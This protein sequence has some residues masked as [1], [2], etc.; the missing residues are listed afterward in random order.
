MDARSR[1]RGDK[2]VPSLRDPA[3]MRILHRPAERPGA[4]VSDSR[5]VP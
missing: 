5:K 3:Y 4:F 2:A 1:A